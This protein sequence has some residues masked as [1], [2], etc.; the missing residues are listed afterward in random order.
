M[1]RKLRTL[2]NLRNRYL[3]L[4]DLFLLTLTPL[5]ALWL[6]TED[7]ATVNLYFVPLVVY[8]VLSAMVKV[9]IFIWSGLYSE[10]WPYASVQELQ[11]LI[12][13]TVLAAGAVLVISFVAFLPAK[14]VAAGFP[15][16]VPIIDAILTLFFIGGVR[17]G[18]RVLYF[19][20]SQTTVPGGQKPALIAGAGVA[21]AMIAKELRT[22]PQLGFT[23]IGFLD[24]DPR[25]IRSRIH[26]IAVLGP[27]R[28]LGRVCRDRRV[29]LVIVAMPTAP[30]KVIRD[31]LHWSREAGVE[32]KTIP[33]LFEILH[34]TARVEQF[35]SI[36][37][38]DLLRRGTIH[39][40]TR[41]VSEAIHGKRV[42]VTGAGGSIGAE[43][44]RQ[45]KEFGPT[46]LILLGHGENSVFNVMKEL[47]EVPKKDLSLRPVIADIRDRER[48]ES[49]F[50]QCQPQLVFHAAAHKHVGLMQLNAADAVSNNVLGTRNLIQVSEKYGVGRFVLI[51]TDKAVNP[52]NIMGATKRIAE[53]LVQDA[54]TR[55]GGQF[56]AVRF[57]NVL[58]SRGSVVPL[59]QRQ[60]A[61]GGPLTVTHPEARRF[62]MTIPEAVQ[63]VLQA[64]T[65]GEGGEVFVLDMGEQIKIAELARDII[66]LNK[67]EEGKDI[68]IV[69]TG[70]GAGEKM[71]EELFRQDE[72]VEKTEHD[73]ILVSRLNGGHFT[74]GRSST[75]QSLSAM[76]DLLLEVSREGSES[77]IDA[78]LRT[79]IPEF[80]SS[81]DNGRGTFQ[82]RPTEAPVD[83][84][85]S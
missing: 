37:L 85:R 8:I 66:R 59:L 4:V 15:R 56:V 46:E 16:S 70:L 75:N 67:L 64:G 47:E 29:A 38:E 30:G 21:G 48:M 82:A 79:I 28:H 69:Y 36:Q 18:I 83:G 45:I 14:T 40:D 33:G 57:G 74:S 26:G 25:K 11:T 39:T 65:M 41:Q 19:L 44:C 3:L 42:L 2:F 9:V 50:G 7:I 58:G 52:T 72:P 32:S 80:I 61:L 76:V 78:V 6:R 13:S 1:R 81:R 84:T 62:F 49:V 53:L 43:L 10:Y 63:L 77:E 23:P 68:D 54:A 73:K 35:R 22:N 71:E 51:S 17:L 55:D 12:K 20:Y 27:L 60:L 31:V 5:L 34:G 24:D